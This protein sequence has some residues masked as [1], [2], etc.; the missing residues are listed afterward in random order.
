MQFL[1][2]YKYEKGAPRQE[3]SKLSRV[4]STFLG[5]GWSIIGSASLA[6]GG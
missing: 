2:F 6:K 3:I 1:D 5:S 4:G